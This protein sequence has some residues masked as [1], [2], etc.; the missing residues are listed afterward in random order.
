MEQ[1]TSTDCNTAP[2]QLSPIQFQIWEQEC[3]QSRIDD[4]Q[5]DIRHEDNV[6]NPDED[7]HGQDSKDDTSRD[8]K[9]I[10]H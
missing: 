5:Y 7:S 8:N 4:L 9:I 3:I 10:Y 2:S 6:Y 1:F